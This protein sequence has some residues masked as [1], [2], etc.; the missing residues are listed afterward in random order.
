MDLLESSW[1]IISLLIIGIVLLVDPK[2]S[3]AGPNNST[4]LGVNSSSEQ[5]IYKFSAVLILLFFILTTL[6]SLSS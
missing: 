6:L 3:L 4:M 5:S 1:F 2:S